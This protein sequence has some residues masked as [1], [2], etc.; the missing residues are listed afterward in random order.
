MKGEKGTNFSQ[1]FYLC[2]GG[3]YPPISDILT[4]VRGDTGG[5]RGCIPPCQREG[6]S[7]IL[8]HMLYPLPMNL[9]TSYQH[10]NVD[11][12]VP[13]SMRCLQHLQGVWI[14]FIYDGEVNR[15]KQQTNRLASLSP[16][17][18]QVEWRGTYGLQV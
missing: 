7:H 15:G 2:N 17:S 12:F 10:M 3:D 11:K 16:T 13:R 6:G 8:I 1:N 18:F 9:S 14:T 4:Y 5:G